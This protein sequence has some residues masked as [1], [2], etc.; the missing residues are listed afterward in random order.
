MLIWNNDCRGKKIRWMLLSELN[1]CSKRT[2]LKEIY[3]KSLESN[4]MENKL[5]SQFSFFKKMKKE[6]EIMEKVVEHA[7]K[8]SSVKYYGL[9]GSFDYWQARKGVQKAEIICVLY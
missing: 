1:D 5:G 3:L 9:S 8:T 7:T 2:A 6:K 4:F